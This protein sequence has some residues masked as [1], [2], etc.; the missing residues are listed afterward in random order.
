MLARPLPGSVADFD[1]RRKNFDAWLRSRGS[2]VLGIS[3]EYE[4][5]RFTTPHG[6]GVIYRNGSDRITSW[7]GGSDEAFIAFVSSQRWRVSTATPAS[8]KVRHRIQAIRER[9]GDGCWYC[10][11]YL[12]DDVTVEHLLSRIH[13]GPNRIENLVL[14]HAGCNL[15][16]GHLSVA[17]KV[18]LRE[19]KRAKGG[20]GHG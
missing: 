12:G 17:E 9:D 6:V 10:G 14:A 19:A 13:E 11:T 18:R 15:G 7:Q 3:N 16:A 2:E 1:K 4:V 5:M 8:S 20:K